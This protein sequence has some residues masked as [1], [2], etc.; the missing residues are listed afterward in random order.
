VVGCGPIGLAVI[1]L[2]RARGVRHVIASDYSPARRSLAV[3]CG[4]HVVV[5]PG[6]ESPWTSF[7]DSRYHTSAAELFDLAVKTMGKL[8]AVPLLPWNKLLRA[9]EAA[10]QGPRGPVVFECVGTPG[11]I[12]HIVASAP[13][14]SRVIVLGVCLERDSF[15]PV[16]AIA[17][18]IALQFV[19]AYDPG[20]FHDT[21][22]LIAEGK[23]DP[24]ALVTSTVGLAEVP[25]AFDALGTA[26]QVK[27]LVAPS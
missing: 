19:L 14:Y 24:S 5:D 22:H 10:G 17:K 27:V 25:A 23:V 11:V 21:L 4:A 13:L 18:E 12:D 8:R 3:R 6:A 7:A 20:E 1:L 15:A 26:E 9:A 2:L 16:T